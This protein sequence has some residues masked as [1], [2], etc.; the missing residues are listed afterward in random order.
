M[1][2]VINAIRLLGDEPEQ[3][4]LYGL[5]AGFQGVVNTV[6]AIAAT[7]L[8]NMSSSVTEGLR[9]VLVFYAALSIGAAILFFVIVA[10]ILGS[11]ITIYMNFGIM[12][13]QLK[14]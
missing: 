10:I 9:F 12:W 2:A 11:A 1:G 5:Y 8:I 6:A 13:Q 3:G 4:G 14:S 7:Y